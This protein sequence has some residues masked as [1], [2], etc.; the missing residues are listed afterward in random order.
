MRGHGAGPHS[1]CGDSHTF[2]ATASEVASLVSCPLSLSLSVPVLALH[3]WTVVRLLPD[4]WA[5]VVSLAVIPRGFLAGIFEPF[6]LPCLTNNL[7]HANKRQFQ[8]LGRALASRVVLSLG[9]GC[10][11]ASEGRENAWVRGASIC[12]AEGAFFS[13]S[14]PISFVPSFAIFRGVLLSAFRPGIVLCWSILDRKK[15]GPFVLGRFSLV[16]GFSFSM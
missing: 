13:L 1:G 2:P 5:C 4:V 6:C 14:F 10:C 16:F 9:L 7:S 12:G 8:A 15:N 11:G 3:P